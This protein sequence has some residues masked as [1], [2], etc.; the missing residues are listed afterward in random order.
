[1]AA[2]DKELTVVM[3]EQI[4]ARL[5]TAAEKALVMGTP[6]FDGAMVATN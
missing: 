4:V 3:L 6:S 5:V 1:M 2:A